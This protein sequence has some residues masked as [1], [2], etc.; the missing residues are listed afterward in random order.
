MATSGQ[1]K[2]DQHSVTTTHRD[3]RV[4]AAAFETLEGRRLF[5]GVH[6]EE[7]PAAGPEFGNALL[8]RRAVA[9]VATVESAQVAASIPKY[10]LSS[11]PAL[12]SRPGARATLYLD[13]DGDT[14]LDW[15]TY[16]PGVTPAVDSDAD[17]S[18][19]T[20]DE[21]A[22]IR[23]AWARVAEDFAPF[24]L[25]VTT[26]DPGRYDNRSAFR[27][28]VGGDS[29]WYGPRVSGLGYV[30]AFA[31]AQ[32]N[33]AFVFVNVNAPY[34]ADII[35]HEAG[36]GFGL[37]H[38][39][40]F[41]SG[42][43][44]L[45]AYA[46]G[47][48]R[49]KPIMGGAGGRAV[50]W[51]G[52]SGAAGDVQD[53]A[54]VIAGF[55]NGFGFRADDHSDSYA[56]ASTLTAAPDG[57]LVGA[58]VIAT[59]ADEDF[60]TF[61]AGGAVDVTIEPAAAAGDLD[62]LA[63]LR[64]A[65]GALVQVVDTAAPVERFTA[66]LTAG[67]YRLG[68]SSHG[69][70]GDLGQYTVR[71]QPR[72]RAPVGATPFLVRPLGT[73]TI[74]AE[75]F[76]LGGEGVAYHDTGA[77]NTGGV[78]RVGEGVDLKTTTDGGAGGY[79]LSDTRAGEWVE[80]TIDVAAAGQYLMEFRVSNSA[81]G[82]RFHAEV[83]GANVTGTMSVPDTDSFN[84]LRTVA[85]TVT[86]PAGRHVLRLAFDAVATGGAT[87]G[88]NWLR[89]SKPAA[90]PLP[91]TVPTTTEIRLTTPTAAYVRAGTTANVNYGSDAR[92]GVKGSGADSARETYLKFDLSSVPTIGSA[93]LRL[94][95][96]LSATLAGGVPVGVHAAESSSWS[97]G[98][99]TWNN[100]P[101]SSVNRLATASVT[102]TSNTWYEWDLSAFLRAEKA[103][104]KRT[105]TLVLKGGVPTSPYAYF[106]SDEASGGRPEL[107]I[108]T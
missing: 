73:T 12:S 34:M 69:R 100:R 40:T 62:E 20:D 29:E 35:S 30:G 46:D 77:A 41:T 24:D 102:G 59:L 64:D 96:R 49:S 23:A 5:C 105:V 33:T 91:P 78:Y 43:V 52:E 95:G 15:G 90:A 63:E 54:Q 81:P 2:T 104:G 85:K 11:L 7:S 31:N 97:E 70:A 66:S 14:T 18:T 65:A 26:V 47:D 25:N 82:G 22:T 17:P 57:S 38:Q 19:F 48:D 13:F 6:G 55:V 99:L 8:L 86:L 16:R 50:W 87:A 80:Y 45:D 108:T 4:A 44:L 32:P 28:V 84:P 76:D 101:A 107:R 94:N 56:A 88:V 103:A 98:S 10:P 21:L 67:S 83:G 74:Q 89:I 92:L 79:R 1:A 68:V 53:D 27:V 106:N 93:K 3:G 75:A 37:G 36:H 72:T 39:E 51:K 42:G 60:F 58:G 9:A 61:G 71:V